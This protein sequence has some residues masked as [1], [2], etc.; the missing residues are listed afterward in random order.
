MSTFKEILAKNIKTTRSYLSQLI[1]MLQE[2]ISGSVSRKKYQHFVTGGIGPGVTSSLYQ[3]VF[4]QDFSLQTSNPMFDVTFGLYQSGSIVA[5]SRTGTDSTGKD[6][7]PSS[8]LMMREK[9]DMYR[10]FSQMLLGSRD[11]QFTA[12]YGSSNAS[13]A[14][15]AALFISMKRLFSRDSI[16]RESFAM[17]FYTSASVIA[18]PTGINQKPNL[19]ITSTSGSTIYTDQGASNNRITTF[20]GAVGNIID[21]SN[22]NTT[23]GLLF[24]ERGV[25]VFDIAK[26]TS[27]SQFMSG[28]IDGMTSTGYQVLGG[29]RTETSQTA[30]LI[31][32]FLVSG[33]MDNV[34]DHFCMTRFQSGSQTAITFQNTTNINSTLIVVNADQD[35]FN[36]SSNPTFVDANNRINVID[37]GQEDVQQTFTYVTTIGLYDANDNLLVVGKLSR[38]VEKS[39]ERPLSFTLRLDF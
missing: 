6:L 24:Y 4:D 36:Y 11:S 12:P 2:D 9:I 35:E 17:R 28:T 23:V 33:S 7:F 27:G 30:K 13:D 21:A 31:P 8:S 32:D 19:T 10:Q 3:T 18:N 39:P 26:I 29:A 22:V 14:I 20:G 15:D 1:D 5:T 16:K 37:A 25:A 34:I 38:P